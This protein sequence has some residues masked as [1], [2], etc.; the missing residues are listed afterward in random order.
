M[1]SDWGI[2]QPRPT[3]HSG[4]HVAS[5]IGRIRPERS[6]VDCAAN[7]EQDTGRDERVFCDLFMRRLTRKFAAPSVM[8]TADGSG[9][10]I[11]N[12]AGN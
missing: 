8:G 2:M 3:A 12:H 1:S 4:W 7:L 11:A 9:P 6:V 10:I 5:T